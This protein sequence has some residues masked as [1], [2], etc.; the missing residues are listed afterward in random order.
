MTGA[1]YHDSMMF[2]IKRT[3]LSARKALD[4]ALQEH[5]L[6]G[7]QFELLRHVLEQD[8]IDQ[9]ALQERLQ[10]SSPSITGLVDAL[11]SRGLVKR[12]ADAEDGRVKRLFITRQGQE[13]GNDVHRKAAGV[14]A[15]ILAGFS[16]AE[17]ALAKEFFAR[18]V[19]NLGLAVDDEHC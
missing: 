1:G 8:G 17:R 12:M 4:Q 9:R 19:S 2:W 7:S 10:I 13:L 18:M 5:G 14:E 15:R 11:V 3:Y 6:T 16:P